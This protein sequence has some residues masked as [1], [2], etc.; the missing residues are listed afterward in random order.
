MSSKDFCKV[1]GCTLSPSGSH[2]YC[3]KHFMEKDKTKKKTEVDKYNP[4][5]FKT[6]IQLFNY[7]HDTRK[8]KGKRVSEISERKLGHIQKGSTLWR[9]TMMHVLPKGKYKMLKLHPDNMM[10]GHPE[11]HT[12]LDQGTEEQRIEY[13]K[14][15]NCSFQIFYDKQEELLKQFGLNK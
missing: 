12:L 7:V 8:K 5:G 4:H 2:G 9:C 14:K 13:E 6:Q 1:K 11:E 3:W 15:W 10:L